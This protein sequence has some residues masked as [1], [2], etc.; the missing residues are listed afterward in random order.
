M[1]NPSAKRVRKTNAQKARKWNV[2]AGQESR[3]SWAD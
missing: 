3:G 2:I 1:E